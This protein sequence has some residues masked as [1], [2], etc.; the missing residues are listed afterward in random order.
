MSKEINSKDLVYYFKGPI[1]SIHFGKYWG[2]LYISGY[3]KNGE[4]ILQDAEEEQKKIKNDLREI[5]SGNPKNKSQKQSYTIKNVRTLYDLWQKIIDLLNDNAK[6]R[7]E[8]KIK[9]K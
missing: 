1:A 5:T 3:I 4:T 8:A 6:I 2:P 9:T 7:S